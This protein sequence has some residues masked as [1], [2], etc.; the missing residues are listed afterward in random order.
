MNALLSGQWNDSKSRFCDFKTIFVKINSFEKH[1]RP[2]CLFPLLCPIYSSLTVVVASKLLLH[3][4]YNYVIIGSLTKNRQRNL[5]V[6]KK[7]SCSVAVAKYEII[8]YF[9]L[10]LMLSQ[11]V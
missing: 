6:V 5:N 9:F 3:L 7:S 1:W 11:H 4:I 2:E 8:N 10:G